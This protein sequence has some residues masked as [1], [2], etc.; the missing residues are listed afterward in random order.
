MNAARPTLAQLRLFVAVADH[1]TFS[2][3]AAELGLS[4]STLSEAIATLE[5]TLG[6]PLLRRTR[7]GVTLTDAG[8]RALDHARS[9]VLAVDDLHLAL[10]DDAALKGTLTI[11]SYR[12]AG[13]HLL[14]PVLASLRRTH[15]HLDVRIT[16]GETDG[17]GGLRLIRDG[18][19]DVG[20]ITVPDDAP[21]LTYPLIRDD[22]LAV[23]PA[24]RGRT[25]TTWTEIAAHPLLLS[26]A[27]NTCNRTLRPHLHAHGVTD[28]HVIEVAE[29]D[30]ILAMVEHGLGIALQPRLAVT[31]LRAG[32][33]ALPL[34]TPLTRT[35][36]I[37]VRPGRANLPH[38]SALI[39]ALRAHVTPH[40][41]GLPL[42]AD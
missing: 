18:Q 32:L 20:L 25:P 29:D 21:L 2:T 36:S 27:G 12:S 30:V 9:A 5:R 33:I 10:H 40:A 6:R 42:S 1:G 41:T 11:A 7:T 17:E 26:P 23:F 39:S 28:P 8:T 22:Y 14:A 24:R 19:A 35:L 37:A 16:D 15:P 3:A 38:I 4:Q 34:P 31:P 13:M